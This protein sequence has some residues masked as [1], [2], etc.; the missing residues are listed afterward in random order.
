MCVRLV[1][2]TRDRLLDCVSDVGPTPVF[3]FVGVAMIKFGGRDV[4]ADLAGGGI[5]GRWTWRCMCTYMRPQGYRRAV[6]TRRL[7]CSYR[8]P[9][10]FLGMRP[11][12]ASGKNVQFVFEAGGRWPRKFF[13]ES[14]H[15]L[16]PGKTHERSTNLATHGFLGKRPLLVSGKHVRLSGVHYPGSVVGL[17]V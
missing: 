8:S 3:F 4:Q 12:L 6:G 9:C 1:Y 15:C 14:G 16:L 13:L 17:F 2:T 5:G 7:R 10:I 11:L